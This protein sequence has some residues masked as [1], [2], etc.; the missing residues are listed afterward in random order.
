MTGPSNCKR[1][2]W[3]W[4]KQI[5]I[6]RLQA[7]EEMRDWLQSRAENKQYTDLARTLFGELAALMAANC[8]RGGKWAPSVPMEKKEPPKI[9]FSQVD[10]EKEVKS[11]RALI[12]RHE[13][14]SDLETS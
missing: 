11:L 2:D 7:M 1:T 10:Q 3:K 14:D 13:D 4:R 9:D 5:N 8:E 6:G 12:E